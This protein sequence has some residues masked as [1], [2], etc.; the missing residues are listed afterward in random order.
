[1]KAVTAA[2]GAGPTSSAVSNPCAMG[3]LLAKLPYN[4]GPGVDLDG[5]VAARAGPRP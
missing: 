3:V 1:V 2:V 4:R 5:V